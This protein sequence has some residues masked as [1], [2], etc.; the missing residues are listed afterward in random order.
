MKHDLEYKSPPKYKPY[1]E[2]AT[3]RFPDNE[4]IT[5]SRFNKLSSQDFFYCGK[6]APNGIDRLNN[7][8]GY[9]ESNCV[10][11]CKHCNYVKGNLSNEDFESWKERFVNK[12]YNLMKDKG[13]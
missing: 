1:R 2:R 3:A 4:L 11:C 7:E 6:A 10:A 8:I 9:L 12:Q 5:E 13:K